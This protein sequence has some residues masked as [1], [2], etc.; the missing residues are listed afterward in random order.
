M[1]L[2]GFHGTSKTRSDTIRADKFRHSPGRLGTGV[3]FWSS[4]L[5]GFDL[6]RA[7]HQKSLRDGQYSTDS[8]SKFACIAVDLDIPEDSV[9]DLE[10]AMIRKSLEKLVSERSYQVADIGVNFISKIYDSFYERLERKLRGGIKVFHGKV[11][12]PPKADL[13]SYRSEI[14]GYPG[15]YMV[16]DVEIICISKVT[17]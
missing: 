4:E 5:Y 8:D 9:V 7:W 6:S 11:P 17:Y 14:L 3:Y 12:G 16:L 10:S 15:C 2:K 1:S 13:R